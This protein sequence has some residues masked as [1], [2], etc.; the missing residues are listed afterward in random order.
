[1][2]VA[3]RFLQKLPAVFS[4]IRYN[5]TH[6]N[7]DLG[8]SAS[9]NFTNIIYKRHTPCR[10][11]FQ[12]ARRD[13]ALHVIIVRCNCGLVYGNAKAFNFDGKGELLLTIMSSLAQ[14]ESRSISENVT[15]GIRKS[16]SDG[17]VSMNYKSF[18]GYRR[19]EDD[20]P[21]IV[22]EEAE[23]VR[24][25]YRRFLEGSTVHEIAKAL[26]V[27][28]VSTP[29]KR[30]T[31]SETTVQSIL[32]KPNIFDLRQNHCFTPTLLTKG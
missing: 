29:M 7:S 12:M 1:M 2:R 3:Y 19:G 17:K 23:I 26:T 15:W 20:M 11:Q 24:T 4:L 30:K 28:G 21:E 13:I 8:E 14:E 27:A 32:T 18:L 16:F 9:K 6:C 25:I 22:P 31:W 5:V 10:S